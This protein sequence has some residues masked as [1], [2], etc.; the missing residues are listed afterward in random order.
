MGCHSKV[1]QAPEAAGS[2]HDVSL[3]LLLLNWNSD[4]TLI[5]IW[6]VTACSCHRD[7]PAA[8]P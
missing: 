8:I 4:L 7:R 5:E 2:H 3:K 1:A 6:G